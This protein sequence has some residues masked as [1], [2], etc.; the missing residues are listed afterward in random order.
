MLR[1]PNLNPLTDLDAHQVF[2]NFEWA[3]VRLSCVQNQVW[4]IRR[5]DVRID[6]EFRR[7][8]GKYF[9][10]LVRSSM[11]R[12]DAR[13]LLRSIGIDKLAVGF[14]IEHFMNQHIGS[15]RKPDQVL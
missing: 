3:R 9:A 12:D 10:G 5:D 8:L 11:V 14:G 15:L 2:S 1:P 7:D 6:R 13:S 4:D